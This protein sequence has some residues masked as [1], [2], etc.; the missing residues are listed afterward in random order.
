MMASIQLYW[1]GGRNFIPY[2]ERDE[3]RK[4]ARGEVLGEGGSEPTLHQLGSLGERRTQLE[5]IESHYRNAL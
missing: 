3:D 5:T 1:G 2:R 4:A